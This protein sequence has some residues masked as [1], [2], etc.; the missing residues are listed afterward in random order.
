MKL[1]IV[2]EN[3]L[4]S[5][6]K[7]QKIAYQSEALIYNDFK[8]PPL[9]QTLDEIFEESK[10]ETIYKYEV[11][12]NIVASVRCRVIENSVL[13][14]GRLIVDPAFQNKG[15]ATSMLKQI[16]NLY[17][18]TVKSY[19]LF[20]GHLSEKNLHLYKKLGYKEIKQEPLNDNCML[21]YMEKTNNYV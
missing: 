8:L 5:I 16:E 17:S 21:V 13:Y 12:G 4:H 6:L 1:E 3:D 7:L 20:T 18:H 15:I 14:I 2:E 9:T 11:E 10:Q 19:S